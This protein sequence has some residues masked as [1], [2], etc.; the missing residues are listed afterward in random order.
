MARLKPDQFTV[1]CRIFAQSNYY[2]QYK[3][4]AGSSTIYMQIVI[5]LFM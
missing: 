5:A 2:L 4:K 3:H 1:M